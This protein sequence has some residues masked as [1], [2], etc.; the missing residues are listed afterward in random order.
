MRPKVVVVEDL[1][2]VA[3]GSTFPLPPGTIVS[4]LAREEAGSR[5]ITFV[6]ASGGL[7]AVGA[8]HGGY[9]MKERLKGVLAGGG[10]AFHD[11]GTY[12]EDA[13]DYP[14]IALLVARAVASGRCG[15]GI[16]VDG[17][18]IGS[19]MAANKVKGVR[20][21]LCYD[22]AT[23]RNSREHNFANVLT[24]GGQMISESE[25]EEIV[26]TWLGTPYGA[27]RHRRRVDK[28][29]AIEKL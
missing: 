24:L 4:P 25:M 11:F 27:E 6:E 22:G 21:A 10:H 13:V 7:I 5:R 29:M 1:V 19:A 18:G 23:A 2:H 16:I 26:K 12:S 3:S 17:A 28:I 9:A 15:V 20:A 14:D 8:D